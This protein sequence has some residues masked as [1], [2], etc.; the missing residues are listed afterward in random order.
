MKK[1]VHIKEIYPNLTEC[2]VIQT[3]KF[4]KK[5]SEQPQKASEQKNEK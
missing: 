2:R 3:K 4:N 1:T 5:K